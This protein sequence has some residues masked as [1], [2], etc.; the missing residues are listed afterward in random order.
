MRYKK[1]FIIFLISII[2]LNLS[3]IYATNVNE[4]NAKYF[5]IHVV[6]NSDSIDDQ[7]LKYTVAKKV[8]TYIE[9]ITKDA[10][11][12][13]DSKQIIEQNIQNILNI[14]S[15]TIKENN[16]DYTVKAYIGRLMYDE[17]Q[18]NDIYM[19][20]GIYDSLKIV[21]GKGQGQNWWSLIYPTTFNNLTQ[22]EFFAQDI[23]YSFGIVELIKNIF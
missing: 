9:D 13:D 11:T 21:I 20:A 17:K 18:I 1:T 15:K 3:L 14:C 10:K 2:L 6:A 12:K 7:L 5:R 22:E 16:S 23:K 19:S 4:N 8:N